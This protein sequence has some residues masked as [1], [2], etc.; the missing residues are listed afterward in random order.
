MNSTRVAEL[1]RE[2]RGRE[3]N[4]GGHGFF[5]CLCWI[6]ERASGV[7]ELYGISQHKQMTRD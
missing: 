1:T 4:G 5:L 2:K 6:A 3:N 7:D